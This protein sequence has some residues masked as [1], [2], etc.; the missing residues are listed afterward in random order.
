[1]RHLDPDDPLVEPT[2]EALMDLLSDAPPDIAVV[3]LARCLRRL[4]LELGGE[5]A[6][7]EAVRL[8]D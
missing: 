7:D 4:A 2:E 5:Q 3:A 6:L 1:M 8:L